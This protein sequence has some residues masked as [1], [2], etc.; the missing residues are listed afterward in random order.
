MYSYVDAAQ[1]GIACSGEERVMGG[2]NLS[3]ENTRRHAEELLDLLVDAGPMTAMDA[4]AKLSWSRG[5]FDSAL[6]FARETLC[7]D[8]GISIPAPTP[9]EG[10]VYAA[11][12]EWEP[13]EAGAAH[14]LGLVES[15]LAAIQ[16]DVSIVLPHLTRGTRE[17]RRASFLNKHLSHLLGTLEEI[18]NG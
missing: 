8:L 1:V 17:W 5:R 15:R 13:V 4:C 2:I 14:T 11:T 6:R 16:R 9:A 10:W 12:T 3:L 18:N 7:L